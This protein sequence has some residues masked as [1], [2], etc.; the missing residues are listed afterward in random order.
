[1]RAHIAGRCPVGAALAA[2]LA[3]L[4]VVS[5]RP[6]AAALGEGV[7]SVEGDRARLAG[8]LRTIELAGYSLHQIEAATGTIVREFASPDGVVF[9]VAWDGPFLPNLRQLLGASFQT[10][11]E[12]ARSRRRGRGPLVFELPDLVF[13]SAGH[14]RGFHGRAYLPQRLPAGF[15][16][17][18]IR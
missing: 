18:T 1:M 2:L 13:E 9:G 16:A 15:S 7:A 5:P 17:E 10:Y 4:A 12:A 11:A 3:L 8:P 14:P 6:A